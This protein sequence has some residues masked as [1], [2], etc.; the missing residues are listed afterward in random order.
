MRQHALIEIKKNNYLGITDSGRSPNI[1]P[2]MK[3]R[4]GVFLRGREQVYQ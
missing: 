4:Q 1:V 3:Q 2:P